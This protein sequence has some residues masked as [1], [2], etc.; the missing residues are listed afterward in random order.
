ML[1]L[2]RNKGRNHS[3]F[4]TVPSSYASDLIVIPFSLPHCHSEKVDSTVNPQLINCGHRLLGSPRTVKR[5]LSPRPS[6]W[7]PRKTCTEYCSPP[8]A[9]ALWWGTEKG[10]SHL[11]LEMKKVKKAGEPQTHLGCRRGDWNRGQTANHM[12]R[13]RQHLAWQWADFLLRLLNACLSPQAIMVLFLIKMAVSSQSLS[14][15]K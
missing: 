15:C 14:L 9:H 7:K 8:P 2:R 13:E 4:H 12:E 5:L 10:H 1:L 11:Q 6:H 3:W